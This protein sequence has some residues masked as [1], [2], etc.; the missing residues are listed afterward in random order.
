METYYD[1]FDI[2]G[3][4]LDFI[5][6]NNKKQNSWRTKP[7][8]KSYQNKLPYAYVA[9][10]RATHLL[11]LAVH[12]DRFQGNIKTYFEDTGNGWEIISL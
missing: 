8:Y 6:S 3:K 12:K 5:S 11:C 7:S 1:T 10:S 2:G 4:I 9:M